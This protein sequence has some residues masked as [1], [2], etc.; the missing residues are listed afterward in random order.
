MGQPGTLFVSFVRASGRGEAAWASEW[1]FDPGAWGMLSQLWPGR[2]AVCPAAAGLSRGCPVVVPN[3]KSSGI[4]IKF[5]FTFHVVIYMKHNF[6]LEST[7]GFSFCFVLH[8]LHFGTRSFT[9]NGIFLT[10]NYY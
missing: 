3:E 8:F 5:K 2:R 9:N 10:T 7:S 4:S 6:S 1:R